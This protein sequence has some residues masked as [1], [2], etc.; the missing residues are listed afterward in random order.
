MTKI[1][2]LDRL[3]TFYNFG[4]IQTSRPKSSVASHDFMVASRSGCSFLMTTIHQCPRCLRACWGPRGREENQSGPCHSAHC[5]F[6][7][8]TKY[9]CLS[10]ESSS[11]RLA[12]N[13]ELGRGRGPVVDKTLA[14]DIVDERDCRERGG[15]IGWSSQVLTAYWERPQKQINGFS[16][17]SH[18][19][20]ERCGYAV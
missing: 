5:H 15:G 13:R 19:F 2:R 4:S 14:G 16:S 7:S 3:S 1:D 17:A 20:P 9:P 6:D 8:R 10:L 12:G 11:D 18:L